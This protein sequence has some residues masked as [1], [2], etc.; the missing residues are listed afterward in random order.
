MGTASFAIF[1]HFL[2]VCT[3][4]LKQKK[5]RKKGRKIAYTT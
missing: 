3:T 4:E 1:M 5:K 2:K